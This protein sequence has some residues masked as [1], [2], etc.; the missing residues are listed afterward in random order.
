M[1]YGRITY[2]D[3]P[4]SRIFYGATRPNMQRGE[5]ADE[6]FEEMFELGINAFDTARNYQLSE[7]SI[8]LWLK[9]SGRRDDV[10]ILSKCG[11]HDTET[12]QKRVTPECMREDLAVSLDLLGTD[13]ID[14]YILHRDDETKPVGPIVE[15]FNSMFEEKKI[16]AFGA[17][18]WTHE[19]I[20]EANAYA[21]EHGLVPFTVSSP[22]YSLGHQVEDPWGGKCVSIGGPCQKE[23]RD[24]Y[25]GT[26]MP[27]ISYSSIARG[28][29]S[30][31]IR[32]DDPEE[33]IRE[34]LDP[35]CMKQF[36]CEEN[37]RRLKRTEE[38]AREKGAAVSQ[39]ALAYLFSSMI[40]S[41]AIISTGSA[42]RM[43]TNIGA[44]DIELTREEIRFLE[45]GKN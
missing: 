10:V 15:T 30:G 44:L 36:Y 35:F 25:A 18:N 16:G 29:F 26:G 17:S 22:N 5:N 2:V 38:L 42:Q 13:K 7:K 39:I 20:A 27:V 1:K 34:A 40:D 11:H 19:R 21:L 32:S 23:A 41:Y 14:I 24:W 12:M 45:E 33:K 31:K 43:Q 28:F 8:G 3:K 4:V 9:H 6:L 37:L